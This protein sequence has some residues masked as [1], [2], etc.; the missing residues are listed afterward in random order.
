MSSIWDLENWPPK[1]AQWF[2]NNKK[3]DGLRP[4]DIPHH[5]DLFVSTMVKVYHAYQEACDKSGLVDFAELLLRAHE[6]WL[7]NPTILK[8]YQERFGHLLVDEFQDTNF[9]QYAWVRMLSEAGA[10]ITIVGDDD[11]SIYGWRGARIENIYQFEKDYPGC[12][13]IRLEQNYRSTSTILKAA[14]AVIANNSERMGKNLWTADSEGEPISV[15]SAFNEVE[16]ARF[17]AARIEDW[18][19]KGNP[20]EEAAILYRSNA[21]S[22]VLEEALIQRQIPY[23]IYGG[24]RFFERAEIKDIL[25]YLRMM[26]N[27]H[28][29]AA[30]ERVVNKPTRGIGEKSLQVVRDIARAENLSLWGGRAACGAQQ[31]IAAA[32]HL[33]DCWFYGSHQ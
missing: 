24:L 13:T 9:I 2:I 23:R 22:R 16:E 18:V 17:I 28:D 20:H 26:A 12:K 29:D 6:L 27:R 31:V 5:G 8:H 1:Q 7:N 3:D 10:A 19:A 30:M 21:Q 11:Q 25:A 15:Y 33:G 14:N 32:S 4:G